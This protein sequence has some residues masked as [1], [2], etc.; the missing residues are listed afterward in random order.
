MRQI[1]TLE[2]GVKK[3]IHVNQHHIRDN[4]KNDTNLP[5][6]SVICRNKTYHCHEI[7]LQGHTQLIYRPKKPL[8]CGARLWGVTKSVVTLTLE[9][10]QT[11]QVQEPIV[12]DKK[13]NT[14]TNLH[15]WGFTK[16][17]K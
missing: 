8:G 14:Q 9:T 15:Q 16:H 11:S 12:V 7:D 3:Y 17:H 13:K 1:H 6:I 2:A 5:P 10:N 4:K